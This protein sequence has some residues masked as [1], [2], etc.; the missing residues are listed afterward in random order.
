MVRKDFQPISGGLANVWGVRM[1]VR[2]QAGGQLRDLLFKP[3][4]EG[5]R[6]NPQRQKE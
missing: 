3:R 4:K 5:E 6:R 1:G 2:V